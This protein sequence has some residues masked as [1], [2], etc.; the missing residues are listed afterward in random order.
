MDNLGKFLYMAAS[1]FLF[2]F[3][4]TASI[5]SYSRLQVYLNSANTAIS[6]ENRAE[7]NIIDGAKKQREITR[8]EI[9]IT[10]FNM[11]Q[12]NVG[13]LTV[14][15]ETVTPENVENKNGKFN[16]LLNNLEM[17]GKNQKFTY[18]CTPQNDIDGNVTFSVEYTIV[19]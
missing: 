7:A 4:T 8:S 14:G 6:I 19:R 5:Y 16:T 15:T 13:S 12:M 11:E 10:L 18:S 3:A 2:I 9:Y 1:A 17:L